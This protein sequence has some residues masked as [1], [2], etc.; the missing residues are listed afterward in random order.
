ML[1]KDKVFISGT[2]YFLLPVCE[3]LGSIFMHTMLYHVIV[4]GYH[5]AKTMFKEMHGGYVSFLSYLCHVLASS[6]F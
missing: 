4:P 6:S 5:L 3:L 2:F 1:L